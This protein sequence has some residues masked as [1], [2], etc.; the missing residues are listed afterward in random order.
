MIVWY[1]FVG[2]GSTSFIV[3][4][5]CTGLMSAWLSLMG[6]RHRQAVPL[7][8]GSMTKLLHHC[9][10]LPVPVVP[11]FRVHVVYPPLFLNGLY[12]AYAMCLGGT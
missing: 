8:V 5:L 7:H 4:P 2:L 6:V 1:A 9:L 12:S 10:F 3:G 11:V